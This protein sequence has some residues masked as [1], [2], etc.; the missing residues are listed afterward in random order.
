[1]QRFHWHV[2]SKRIPFEA[3]EREQLL[4]HVSSPCSSLGT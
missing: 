3:I 4:V 1:M 2:G